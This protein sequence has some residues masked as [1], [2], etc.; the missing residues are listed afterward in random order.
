MKYYF[1]FLY[2]LLLGCTPLSADTVDIKINY[3]DNTARSVAIA[4]SFNNWNPTAYNFRKL[5]G[6]WEINLHLPSGYYYYKLIVNNRWITDPANP[7][8]VNDGG[9]GFNSILKVG[10]PPSPKRIMRSA[11]FHQ[12]MLPRPY[13]KK[14]PE[15][16]DLYYAAWKMAW[17]KISHGVPG[18]GLEA[19]FMDEGFNEM[20]YQWDTCFMTLFGVYGIDIFPVMA[21]LDNFYKKQ[22][23]DGYIQRV[24]NQETGLPSNEPT[25]DEPMVN[26]PLFAWIELKYYKLTGD[27]T[28]LE[29]VLPALIKYYNWIDNNCR[30]EG[31]QLY[32]TSPLGSGMDNTPRFN[33]NKAGWIDFSA[34]QTLAA[35]CIMEIADIIGEETI[36]QDLSSKYQKNV[37]SINNLCWN[38]N[39]QFYFDLTESDTLS[40]TVHI[41]AYW[42]LLSHTADSSRAVSLVK[43]LYD[44]KHFNR[45][46]MVPTLSFSDKYFDRK[47]HYWHGSVWAPT[48]YMVI[49]GL[50]EYGYYTLADSIALNHLKNIADIYFR[51][52]PDENKIAYEERYQDSYKTIWE[53]Y[54]SEL[55]SPATRWDN[56]FYSRQDFVGWSGLGPI[57]LLIENIL[58]INVNGAEN[59]ITWRIHRDDE[60]GISNLKLKD[61]KI[62]L[63]FMPGKRPVVKVNSDKPFK[64]KINYKDVSYVFEKV[65][66]DSG[67]AAELDLSL[68]TN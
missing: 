17:Q 6:K 23:E 22:R 28:R 50:E 2:V 65:T 21:S 34:Q 60:H 9:D 31:K 13:L 39:K 66:G 49:K 35:K 61:Q 54:S 30:T 16:V 20:I 48:N 12:E 44:K 52:K 11:A 51:F 37:T 27:D 42:T 46:H 5:P 67:K 55:K 41:G 1:V 63:M 26:P 43:Y 64:L 57:S 19:S 53:C 29:R 33:V 38:N 3:K 14:D 56:T 8:K 45:P 15:F 40:N 10:N 59:T 62:E 18:S 36:S 24:Y 4:G 58:G 32:Y 7:L 47:G 68:R 25:A